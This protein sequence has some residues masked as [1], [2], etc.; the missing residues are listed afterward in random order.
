MEDDRYP[1]GVGGQGG[2]SEL[3]V[4]CVRPA[5]EGE[6]EGQETERQLKRERDSKGEGQDQ[7]GGGS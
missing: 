7:D 2:V 1:D 5:G 6:E 4:W 3:S